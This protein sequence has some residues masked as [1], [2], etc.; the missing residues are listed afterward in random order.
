VI[1]TED[2]PLGEVLTAGKLGVRLLPQAYVEDR[3]IRAS[4][5]EHIVGVRVSMRLKANESVLWSDLAT[6]TR[7]RRNLSGL[8]QTGMRAVTIRADVT[9]AFGGLLRPGD[10]VDVLYSTEATREDQATASTIPLLQ[11]VLC[12][13]VGADTGN[14]VGEA[15]GKTKLGTPSQITI[16]LAATVE[17]TQV[18]TYGTGHGRLSLT[19]RNPDDISVL[20]GLPET[21]MSDI[22]EPARRDRVQRRDPAEHVAIERVK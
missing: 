13:A 6:T 2:V 5:V 16:T 18:L 8:V 12:L 1:A 19:L 11:N 3:H 9:S 10:R 4:E 17:Q 21:T 14:A 22:V 20:H 7:D 15:G